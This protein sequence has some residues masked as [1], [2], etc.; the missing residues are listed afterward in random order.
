M[1][2]QTTNLGEKIWINQKEN[3]SKTLTG[4]SPK[5]GIW[6]I[7]GERCST[8]LVIREMQ[9]KTII[10]DSSDWLS[11]RRLTSKGSKSNEKS[12]ILPVGV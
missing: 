1:R 9:I 11:L 7:Y 6:P 12:Q 3:E 10:S 4:T 5:Q 8:S 2:R